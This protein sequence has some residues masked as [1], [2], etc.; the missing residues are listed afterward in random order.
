MAGSVGFSNDTNSVNITTDSTGGVTVT[1][2]PPK[3]DGTPNTA[4]PP[5]VMFKGNG[6]MPNPAPGPGEKVG[7]FDIKV[8]D[9]L[10]L[11][12]E[13]KANCDV[14][15]SIFPNPGGAGQAIYTVTYPH[16]DDTLKALLVGFLKQAAIDAAPKPAAAPV[17]VKPV[18]PKDH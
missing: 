18:P 2:S 7:V 12:I 8:G 14:V 6:T 13:T 16:Q 5:S 17:L 10:Y 11:Q 15:I 3:A 9:P 4:I 1:I